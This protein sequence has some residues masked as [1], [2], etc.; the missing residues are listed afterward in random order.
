MNPSLGWVFIEV[1]PASDRSV[2]DLTFVRRYCRCL[3][4]ARDP[5]AIAGYPSPTERRIPVELLADVSPLLLRVLVLVNVVLTDS[6]LLPR[7]LPV[8]HGLNVDLF[9]L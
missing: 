7:S 8:L 9:S 2:C 6:K 5:V 1:C 3:C 4:E